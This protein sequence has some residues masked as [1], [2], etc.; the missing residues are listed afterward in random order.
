MK[1]AA[2]FLPRYFLQKTRF[3][4]S[5]RSLSSGPDQVEL[6]LFNLKYLHYIISTTLLHASHLGNEDKCFLPT[7]AS[8]RDTLSPGDLVNL[9]E[10]IFSSVTIYSSSVSMRLPLKVKNTGDFGVKVAFRN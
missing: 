8:D 2:G 3:S 9:V 6:K 10:D 4:S 1:S 7:D 5:A